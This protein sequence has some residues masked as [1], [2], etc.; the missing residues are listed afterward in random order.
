MPYLAE[1]IPET[2]REVFEDYCEIC[3][4]MTDHVV[5]QRALMHST[6]MQGVCIIECLECG[7][8]IYA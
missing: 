2:A 4:A 1:K 6:G 5:I 8:Q 7:T 3:G